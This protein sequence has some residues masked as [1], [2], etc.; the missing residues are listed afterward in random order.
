MPPFLYK[1][2]SAY[3]TFTISKNSKSETADLCKQWLQSLVDK[4]RTPQLL[5]YCKHYT[6]KTGELAKALHK[7]RLT[8]SLIFNTTKG[9][10]AL[11]GL[12]KK[13]RLLQPGDW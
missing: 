5:L 10:A 11:V 13:P 6:E 12:L 2:A 4:L 8:L 7:P 3:T 9:S 1:P